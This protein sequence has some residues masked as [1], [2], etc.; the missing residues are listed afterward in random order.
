MSTLA[1]SAEVID[2]KRINISNR[3]L[4]QSTRTSKETLGKQRNIFIR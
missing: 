4:Q 2:N 1:D 3:N